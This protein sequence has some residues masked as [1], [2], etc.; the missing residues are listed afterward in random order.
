MKT[1]R[2]LIVDDEPAVCRILKRGL[3]NLRKGY[4]IVTAGDGY[5]A[6]EYI[7]QA[8]FD[9]IV[10]DYKMAGLDG[11][12]L[13][14]EIRRIQ[15][16]ARVVLMTAYGSDQVE[17]RARRLNAYRYLTKPLE[18][19]DFRQMV[20][21][22]LDNMALSTE[23]MLVLSAQRYQ[24]AA[25]ILQGLQNDVGACCILLVNVLGQTI[26]RQGEEQAMPLNEIVTLLGGGIATLTQAGKAL[27]GSADAIN[28]IYRES[29]AYHLYGINVGEN[30]LMVILI[31][32]TRFS[33]PLGSVWYYARRI[34]EKLRDVLGDISA[35][36]A[37]ASLGEDFTTS[38]GEELDSLF[39]LD[40]GAAAEVNDPPTA[41]VDA[42]SPAPDETL[43]HKPQAV[44]SD[45]PASKSPPQPAAAAARS[46]NPFPDRQLLGFQEA[47]QRGLLPPEWGI[48][49]TS[50]GEKRDE[51]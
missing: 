35:D 22:A 51:H 2:I 50:E 28:L 41:S 24:Q 18:M 3:D 17:A 31:A 37:A 38:L 45:L 42:T 36:Q 23:G 6:L 34:V 11:L 30:L 43:A 16:E 27:D 29:K 26:I 10:T 47:L 25:E 32:N 15:P 48:A 7:K 14:E 4:E 19:D 13:L 44:A 39:G 12:A 20:Q 8:P 33:S 49:S 1:R 46:A 21:E 9:L 5:E 40:E